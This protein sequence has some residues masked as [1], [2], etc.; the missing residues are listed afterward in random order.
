MSPTG[1]SMQLKYRQLFQQQCFINGQ[2]R[3]ATNQQEAITNPQVA[4]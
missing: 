3:A 4:R 1:K 2:W